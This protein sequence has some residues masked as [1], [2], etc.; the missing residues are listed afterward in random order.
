VAVGGE[1]GAVRRGSDSE[2]RGWLWE[3]REGS[4]RRGEGSEKRGGQ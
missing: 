3:E 4:G 1:G 2:K